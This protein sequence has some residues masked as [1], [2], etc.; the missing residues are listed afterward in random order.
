MI[1]RILGEGQLE[2][3][4]G[5]MDGLNQLDADLQDAVD[6]GDEG[7]FRTT[8]ARL[9]DRVRSAGERLPDGALKPSEL[10]LPA[11]EADLAEVRELLGDEGLIPG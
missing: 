3:P 5:E 9:L 4:D 2:V 11:A 7:R 1:V 8:L 6:A 10:V